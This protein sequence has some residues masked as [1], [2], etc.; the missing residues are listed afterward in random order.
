MTTIALFGGTGR[1]GSRVLQQALAAGLT[2]RMLARDPARVPMANAQLTVVAGDVLDRVAVGQTVAGS[3]AVVSVFGHVKGSPP[4]IQADGTA[5]IVEAM[6][7]DGVTRIVSLSGGGVPAPNDRPGIADR[8]IKLLLR[9]FAG[10]VLEDAIVHV[11]VLEDSGVEWTVVRAPRLTDHPGRGEF[12]VGWVGVNA[13][14][15]ISRDDLAAFVIS[16]ID[17]PTYVRQ[18]PFVSA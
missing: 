11:R 1:T 15:K 5:V 17:D 16:Q 12:R 6:R 13:S 8:V 2:V 7:A 3:D 4:S 14:T 18:M 9:A 10:Q